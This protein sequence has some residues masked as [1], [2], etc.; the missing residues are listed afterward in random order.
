M[1]VTVI[2]IY[3]PKKYKL[4][5]LALMLWGLAIM[6]FVDHIMGYDG[7]PFIEMEIDGLVKD[8]TILGLA[9]LIPIFLIWEI[10]LFTDKFKNEVKT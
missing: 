9:M 1:A 6:V 5:N 7:G 8:G 3:A 2:W 10:Q 4:G